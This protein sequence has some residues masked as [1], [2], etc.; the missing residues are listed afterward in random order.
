MLT[1]SA[2]KMRALGCMPQGRQSFLTH[3]LSLF[4][5]LSLTL[6]Q[7]SPQYHY[8]RTSSAPNMRALGC[9][10]MAEGNPPVIQSEW[11]LMSPPRYSVY[12]VDLLY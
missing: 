7:N 4:L 10:P 1:S 12:S 2:P 3:S 6:S 9:M 5:P 11:S 8:I